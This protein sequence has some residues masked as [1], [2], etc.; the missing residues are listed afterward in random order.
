VETITSRKNP[1]VLLMRRVAHGD[2]DERGRMLLDGV[3][4]MQ[5]ARAAGVPIASAAFST[6]ILNSPDGVARRLA[7]TLAG[8]GCRVAQVSDAVM[9]AMS[10]AST[11]SGAIALAARPR[12]DLASIL[13]P[14]RRDPLI[15]V[16][17]GVQDPG[18]LGAIVRVAE[19]GGA[20]GVIV[21]GAS[22][23]PYGWKALR[24]AMGS[25]FRLPIV[26]EPHLDQVL[27]ALRLSGVRVM[28]A[29]AEGGPDKPTQDRGESFSHHP[30]TGAC[31]V[32]LGG[33]GS[34]LSDEVVAAADGIITI[35]M[36]PP[37]ESL[38]VAVSAALIVYEA[39]RQRRTIPALA[40][41]SRSE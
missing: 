39:R 27:S 40:A 33:E 31:A 23:D 29:D 10:P 4:L 25:A 18:N 22:A 28:A 15:C 41:R 3:H 36:E 5:E 19:A 32:L 6:R 21:S 2:P 13:P 8:L 34:G 35:P 38:N 11:P 16:A 17:V 7:T 20:T 30:L 9:E 37:V 1:L 12:H 26:R 24:G 14:A